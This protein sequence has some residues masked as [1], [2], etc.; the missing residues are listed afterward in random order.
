MS[1]MMFE[2]KDMNI[3][4]I[5]KAEEPKPEQEKTKKKGTKNPFKL[6]WR[7]AKFCYRKVRESPVATVIGTGI[8]TGL[9]LGVKAIL[10]W[11]ASR[12]E[13]VD[14]QPVETEFIETANEDVESIAP[15]E[16]VAEE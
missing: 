4:E 5:P 14:I 2:E 9:T 8:G 10:D 7:G 15:P 3:P 11:R 16:D 6:A 1:E 13:T 12:K